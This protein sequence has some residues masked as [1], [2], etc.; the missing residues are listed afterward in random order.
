[1]VVIQFIVRS[2]TI[3]AMCINFIQF[4]SQFLTSF[5]KHLLAM[6]WK[7]VRPPVIEKYPGPPD[8]PGPYSMLLWLAQSIK[9]RKPLLQMS[10]IKAM[11]DSCLHTAALLNFKYRTHY[12][13]KTTVCSRL[14]CKSHVTDNVNENA[15]VSINEGAACITPCSRS[16]R[17]STPFSQDLDDCM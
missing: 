1:M 7:K 8:P 6:L 9:K 2:D 16:I 14:S 15:Y 3:I 17:S 13:L 5:C 11:P 4:S 12:I 10:I